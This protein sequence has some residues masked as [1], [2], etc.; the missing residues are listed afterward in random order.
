[1]PAWLF[2][3]AIEGDKEVF[4]SGME[5]T[6]GDDHLK[7]T[8]DVSRT[9]PN[10]NAKKV[11][12]AVEDLQSVTHM[13]NTV[14]HIL[15][16]YGHAELASTICK[17]DGSMWRVQNKMLE[18]PF[19]CAA[20]AWQDKM[21][22]KLIE[23]ARNEEGQ[24]KS[25]L[26]EKNKCGETALH[27]AARR[28]YNSV[29]SE[30][31]K[32]D[33]LLA[34]EFNDDGVSPLYW[35]AATRKNNNA[36]LKI[37]LEHLS[38]HSVPPVYSDGRNQKTAVETPLQN[39]GTN[40]KVTQMPNSAAESADISKTEPIHFLASTGSASVVEIL[41]ESDPNLAYL[42]DC[43]GLFP[44]HLAARAG[45]V[46]MITLFIEMFP[47][48]G[49]LLDHR[50]RNFFHIAAEDSMSEVF[51][52]LLKYK[53]N[54]YNMKGMLIRMLIRMINE[55]DSK[56]NTPLHLAAEKGYKSVVET[57]C[58]I[59][60]SFEKKI[61]P[62]GIDLDLQ[63]K[64]GLTPFDISMIQIKSNGDS[65][66]VMEERINKYVQKHGPYFTLDWFKPSIQI[67]EGK[68]PN[69]MMDK[70]QLI[71]L[72]AVLITTVAFAVAFTLPGGYDSNGFPVLGRKYI[73]KAFILANTLAFT[74]SALCVVTT[75]YGGL[76]STNPTDEDITA[77][78]LILLSIG[79]KCMIFAFGLGLYLMLGGVSKGISI[80]VLIIIITTAGYEIRLIIK[81]DDKFNKKR[82]SDDN[83]EYGWYGI[84]G[85]A[86]TIWLGS[87]FTI[88]LTAYM[89]FVFLILFMFLFALIP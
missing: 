34:C 82:R 52:M 43:K 2:R 35:A 61:L 8:I 38:K 55:T 64:K 40:G 89:V 25:V 58:V 46:E 30:L 7:V 50:G 14:L 78:P 62:N 11:P 54:F 26:R 12:M 5:E 6:D 13:G 28:G 60:I 9:S 29:V 51:A 19:H 80:L 17:Q 22:S 85:S 23:L 37:M 77:I 76:V 65:S 53:N 73:F 86:V 31:M 67:S 21:F 4:E 1:M 84:V 79:V 15:A 10:Q 69:N 18:T 57:I 66:L 72:G 36:L 42:P 81:S 83:S 33:P 49:E 47:D 24:L 71:G 68:N 45:N 41:L 88:G 75:I 16:A 20:K 3:A 70:L 27:E 87:E 39:T 32:A 44:I 56:G 48:T 59:S 74:I 63:N